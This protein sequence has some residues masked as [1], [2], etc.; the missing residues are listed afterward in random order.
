M[1]VEVNITKKY[2]FVFL[3]SIIIVAGA[4]FVM[5]AA[6]NPGHGADRI[7]PGVFSGG[8]DS[9]WVFPGLIRIAGDN[10][11]APTLEI[12]NWEAVAQRNQW[13]LIQSGKMFNI[14]ASQ[15]NL[16]NLITPVSINADTGGVKLASTE[17][18][19]TKIFDTI[20]G[21]NNA[22]SFTFK[23]S[24][25]MSFY[26]ESVNGKSVVNV[27]DQLRTKELCIGTDCKTDWNVQGSWCGWS[28]NSNMNDANLV[29]CAGFNP[30]TSC[31][32][33]FVKRQV[34]SAWACLKT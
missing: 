28:T 3:A 25:M 33:G 13:R 16:Q 6:P 31:P 2:M 26:I 8:T 22:A 17:I 34:G 20:E 32:T 12:K 5:A 27:K 24:P 9:L 7:G 15:E 18:E 19:S 30:F 4:F 23:D 14:Q 29:K 1:K 10:A 11:H 21:I